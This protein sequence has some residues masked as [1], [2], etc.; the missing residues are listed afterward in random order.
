MKLNRLIIIL[1]LAL[2]IA[3][4]SFA[5][6]RTVTNCAASG[7]GSL[8]DAVTYANADDIINFDIQLVNCGYSTG[9]SGPGLVTTEA[10]SNYWFRIM[11]DQD[12]FSRCLSIENDGIFING[13]SQARE[14]TNANGPKIEIRA[15]NVTSFTNVIEV[16]NTD[17]VTIEGVA[18]NKSGSGNG[19]H[20]SMIVFS[21][22]H[23]GEV[24][25]S[26]IGLSASGEAAS[27]LRGYYGVYLWSNS[28]YN[29][30]GNGTVAGRNVISGN[31]SG[32]YLQSPGV[33]SNEVLGNYIGTNWTGLRDLGNTANGVILA[34]GNW[35]RVGDG[36]VGGRNI[37]SGN[38]SAGVYIYTEANRNEVGGNYIG[39]NVN[40]NAALAN[41]A[42][43][44]LSDTAYRNVIGGNGGKRNIISGNSGDGI[45]ITQSTSNEVLN[46]YIGLSPDGL[47][48]IQ[49]QFG[50][51]IINNAYGNKIGNG[52][53]AGRNVVSGSSNYGIY[54]DGVA[55]NEVRGNYI[56]TTA[57]GLSPLANALHGLG[58]YNGAHHNY[59]GDGTIDGANTIS[60]NQTSGIAVYAADHNYILANVIGL[61]GDRQTN[62]K[63]GDF[64]IYSWNGSHHNY[65]YQNVVAYNGN[66][67]W[68]E[69]IRIRGTT[70]THETISQN[71]VY[72]NYGEGILLFQNSNLNIPTPEIVSNDYNQATSSLQLVATASP[73]AT[74]EFFKA[75]GGE[76]KTYLGN[77]T[78]SATGNVNGSISASGLN[79]GDRL[80]AT[81]TGP[82]GDTSQFSA[83]R[84]VSI[85]VFA[86]YQPDVQVATLESG[87][88][89]NA[90]GLYENPPVT[91]VRTRNVA[92]NET[93]VAFI[94]VQN[95]GTASE[96]FLFTATASGSGFTVRY[97]DSRIGGN[98]ITSLMLTPGFAAVFN[99][100]ASVE[101][102]VEVTTSNTAISTK[103]IVFSMTS[104]TDATKT[105]AVKAAITFVPGGFTTTTASRE[106]NAAQ[107]GIPGMSISI[108][109]GASATDPVITVT[110]VATPGAAPIG[111]KIG[112]KVI[113][114]LS[115]VTTFSLPVTV[116]IPI[117]G[118]LADPRVYFWDGSKWSRDGIVVISYTN[119]SITFTTTHFTVFT[120][121]GV[122]PT[123]LV[124][125]GPN[126]Y[127]P[128]SG[129][130]AKIWY[131]LDANAETTIYIV[132][133]AG[134]VVLKT[135]YASGAL[136][137]S[138]G[139]N[140]VD[141]DGK[142]KW[143]QVLGDGAYLYKIVQ[144][145]KVIGGGKIGIVK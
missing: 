72:S 68:P 90:A 45:Q 127:N 8:Y 96:M 41:G 30:I 135:T 124:R 108:P 139:A 121:M 33:T 39:L 126:P 67:T 112:G 49:N 7:D 129:T 24:L 55:S 88:D 38:D 138:A 79:T 140:N 17:R 74:V 48:A 18:V 141:F 101:V 73:F 86:S 77:L 36:T 83:S 46:N 61:G 123:N 65:Y 63:N 78:A 13:S 87:A 92:T 56:G 98:D 97:F 37:I 19:Q 84:E 58:L 15:N 104:T 136:G 93:G 81:Q 117:D 1:F 80:V 64:G 82:F 70:T 10:G 120:S 12:A 6:T 47:S 9:E 122:L 57:N 53:E 32:V 116:T 132:D 131:W 130:M 27:P 103:E 128:N 50:I 115:S 71:S 26:Y 133:L 29:K 134:T 89:Y 99:S 75:F 14:A 100:G 40:G 25:N 3:A 125:F 144:G 118:P 142:D 119:T 34:Q 43:I 95:T 5:A 20:G 110:E 21:S 113:N 94:K 52:T 111:Y 69:G 4:P 22:C 109:A 51:R 137:G 35:N 31:T 145:G 42:G 66:A 85:S 60:G 11:L 114:I 16:N 54:L 102:R 107:L 143:G 91:Q 76:G 2:S 59:I 28:G 105:D 62:V 23:Y 106:Y 44:W